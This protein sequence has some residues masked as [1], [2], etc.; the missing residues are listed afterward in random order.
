[1]NREFCNNKHNVS[2]DSEVSVVGAC[3]LVPAKGAVRAL[4][5]EYQSS[6]I[7]LPVFQKNTTNVN[8]DETKVCYWTSLQPKTS[9]NLHSACR[10][11]C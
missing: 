6:S 4:G 1:M 10:S 11:V 3:A 7:L 9:W 2:A 8:V 5:A